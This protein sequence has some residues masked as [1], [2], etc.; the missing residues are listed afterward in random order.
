LNFETILAKDFSL[1]TDSKK[2]SSLSL[3]SSSYLF[4]WLEPKE[5]KVQG[6]R[7]RSPAYGGTSCGLCQANAQRFR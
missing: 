5:S 7:Q 4:F 1:L 3:L 2:T 6:K